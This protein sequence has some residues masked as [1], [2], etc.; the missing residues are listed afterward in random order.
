MYNRL[1]LPDLRVMLE[2][3]D[4]Q[5]M[6]EFCEALHP[7]VAAEVLEELQTGETWRVVSNCSFE[8]QGEILGFLSLPYQT[9]LVQVI[10]REHLSHLIET[11]APDDRVDLLERMEP[12]HVEALLPLIAQAERSDI[13]KLLSYPE[14][15]A[16]S[17][18]TTE[19]ASLSEGITVTE[20]LEWLRQ[21]APDRETI[22]YIYIVDEDRRLTGFTSLRQLILSNP[23][24]QLSEFMERDVIRVRVDDDQELVAQELARYDFIAIPVVDN[25]NQLVG[26]VTYDDAMDVFREEATEDVHRLGAI[27]PL[28]DS[29]LETPISTIA[30]KR[31]I[32]LMFLAV[33]A[34]FT[35]EVLQH[36]EKVT[37]GHI[38]LIFFLPL[39]LASG[40]NAG[41]QSAT[42]IIRALALG[43]L[44]EQENVRMAR[45]EL[46]VGC[47]LG[48]GLALV[49]FIAASFQ[50]GRSPL[51]AMV[52]ASTVFLVVII[53]T[54]SGAVLPL[55]CRHLGMD[56]A[57]MSTP[58]IAALVDVGG[59]VIYYTVAINLLGM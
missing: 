31:G 54:F 35:A 29:Y 52:V 41:A 12:E 43:D 56:P 38:W 15:S 44:T 28:E 13:R 10:G 49:S 7:A 51:E 5:A 46:L 27:D 14:E 40:G 36:Y 24:K 34:L 33:V 19:Y 22:Y 26:I 45:R 21:Q 53:G 4:K 16:G 18:M 25:Q 57:V 3:D 47:L 2:E 23:E 50:F 30:W 6:T 58:L 9:E 20:A 55:I 59:A 37:T 1:L 17:I 11:M 39:V 8:Q 48:I 42:L 32:W